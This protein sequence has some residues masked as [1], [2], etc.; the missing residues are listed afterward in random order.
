MLVDVV[1]A[2]PVRGDVGVAMADDAGVERA[3]RS[4]LT[5]IGSDDSLFACD[6]PSADLVGGNLCTGDF[7]LRFRGG[8]ETNRRLHFALLEKLV[9]LL[10]GAGSAD[11]LAARLCLSPDAGAGAKSGGLALQLRLE[12][13]GNSAEQ[14]SLRWGL[15]VV[16]VQQALLFTS[17]YLRQQ[18]AQGGD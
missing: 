14:A 10:R 13:R 16:H 17:R 3:V 18:V 6:A 1:E 12:A 2:L 9:E 7:V 5:A 15:G 8:L 11:T 4:F